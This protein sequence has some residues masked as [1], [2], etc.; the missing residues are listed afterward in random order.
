MSNPHFAT[1]SVLVKGCVTLA[2]RS[3]P[4]RADAAIYGYLKVQEFL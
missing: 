1:G 2:N 4:V 3:S